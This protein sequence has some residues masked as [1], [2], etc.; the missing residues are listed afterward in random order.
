MYSVLNFERQDLILFCTGFDNKMIKYNMRSE[1]KKKKKKKKKEKKKKK[2]K[3]K[4]EDMYVYVH[5]YY[6]NIIVKNFQN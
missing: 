2:G 1:K 3:K 5:N 4:A 6:I